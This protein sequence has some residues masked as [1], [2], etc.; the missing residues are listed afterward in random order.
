MTTFADRCRGTIFGH[1][2][3]D[4]LG[5]GAE[6]MSKAEVKEKYPDGLTSLSQIIRDRHRS[7]WKL[8]AWTDDTDQMLCIFDSILEQQSV[9]VLDIAKR[10]HEWVRNDGMGVGN[11]V[12]S[13]VGSRYFLSAPHFAAQYVWESGERRSASNGGV[14]RTSILGLWRS[15]S[16]GEVRANAEKVCRITH[17]DPRCVGSCV[18][19]SSAIALLVQGK[20]SI[21]E[22][23]AFVQH[24]TSDFSP[25]IAEYLD[26]AKAGTL[27]AFDLDEGLDPNEPDRLGFTLKALGAGFWALKHASSYREGVLQVIHEGGDADTNGAVAGALLGARDGFDAIPETWLREL[28]HREA[29]D[30]RVDRLFSLVGTSPSLAKLE[31]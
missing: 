18:A 10:F 1:A 15:D 26:L 16:L 2:V 7:R 31:T 12:W 24:E 14:M 13:V 22:I 5:L 21:D 19:V 25:E 23:F 3:A 6:F 4:A 27:E 11:T 8:G 28:L 20:M 29:L 9:N 17:Y 30:R